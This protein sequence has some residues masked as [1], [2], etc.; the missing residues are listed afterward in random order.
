MRIS[1]NQ[2]YFAPYAGWYRLLAATDVFVSLDD[3]Q[4]IRRGWVNRCEL[5][6]RD[7]IRDWLTLPVKKTERDSTRIMDLQW[8][9]G[10]NEIWAKQTARFPVF[11][12][13]GGI[14]H[15]CLFATQF[16]SPLRFIENLR[17]MICGKL[18]LKNIF[19]SSSSLGVSGQSQEKIIS[20]CHKLGATEYVNAP[21]GIN[22]YDEE[23]FAREGITLTFLPP[24]KGDTISILERLAYEKPEE[25][26]KEIY[27]NI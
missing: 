13:L 1:V 22:L 9:E 21:G 24:Y 16:D 18:E 14:T 5:I 17:Y 12:K 20:I 7:G 19:V 26:R 4:H 15:T 27:D 11:D 8:A 10:A 3:V 2:P 25:I 23:A 6:R